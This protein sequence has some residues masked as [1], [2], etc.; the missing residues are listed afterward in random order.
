M[1]RWKCVLGGRSVG[2]ERLR[3]VLE[4]DAVTSVSRHADW[5]LSNQHSVVSMLLLSLLLLT[6]CLPF[7]QSI[8]LDFFYNGL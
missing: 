7:N 5:R 1:C 2:V 3:K 4:D 8:N 6:I